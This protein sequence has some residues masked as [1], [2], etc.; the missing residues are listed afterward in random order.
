MRAFAFAEAP[1]SVLGIRLAAVSLRVWG[2]LAPRP[3]FAYH[4]LA[5]LAEASGEPGLTFIADARRGDWHSC[6]RGEAPQRVAGALLTGALAIPEGFR[7]WTPPPAGVRSVP[8]DVKDLLERAGEADLFRLVT[9]P[10]VFL[11]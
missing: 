11:L 6:R 10:D 2:C 1:G 8:Y 7:H 3:V 9:E 4:A 5:L